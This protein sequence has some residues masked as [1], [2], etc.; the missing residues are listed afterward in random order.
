MY[1]TNVATI[2]SARR[3]IGLRGRIDELAYHG[4]CMNLCTV[5]MP[6]L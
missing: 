6:R 2:A 3:K 4:D 5:D 1:A